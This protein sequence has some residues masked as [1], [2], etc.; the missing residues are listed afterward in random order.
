MYNPINI[1][2]TRDLPIIMKYIINLIIVYTPSEGTLALHNDPSLKINLSNPANRLLMELIKYNGTTLDRE[3]LLR[4][5]WEEYGFTGSNSNLNTY[6]SELRK[7]FSSLSENIKVITT[8][9]KVGF[10]L[11]AEVEPELHA[12]REEK[13]LAHIDG[14]TQRATSPPREDKQEEAQKN[15]NI[16][17][18]TWKN[19]NVDKESLIA[20]Q[21]GNLTTS[22]QRIRLRGYA[23]YGA[24]I[25]VT[26]VIMSLL[27]CYYFQ[28]IRPLKIVKRHYAYISATSDC[29][30][31]PP[32]DKNTYTTAILLHCETNLLIRKNVTEKESFSSHANAHYFSAEED[33]GKMDI[34]DTEKNKKN[35]VPLDWITYFSAPCPR[36]ARDGFYTTVN[37]NDGMSSPVNT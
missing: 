14:L 35:S 25:L 15:E 28:L 6:I 34:V 9:P 17:S 5:V 19:S 29:E 32:D 8:I 13:T 30:V 37:P 23:K 12:I 33:K 24:I 10:R 16:K 27:N 18:N 31:Y 20:G 3:S 2:I 4:N 22:Q 36:S 26:S 7:S 11:E 21:S 1:I